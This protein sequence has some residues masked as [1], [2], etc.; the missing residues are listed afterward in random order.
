MSEAS[1]LVVG[2]VALN[3]GQLVSKIRLQKTVYLL[4]QCGLGGNFEF[5]YRNYGPFSI[6]VA[7]AADDAVAGS[8]LTESSRPGHHAEPYTIYETE[9]HP[10]EKL[11][12]VSSGDLRKK[13]KVMEHYSSLELEVA[14]TIV[15]LQ[16]QGHDEPSSIAGTK[17]LK[18]L[19]AT[20]ERIA[21][22][23]ELLSELEL[24]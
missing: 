14:S 23:H 12:M 2:M 11:G 1:D 6:D 19:K 10:P 15:F 4:E 13:L 16:R 5:E 7:R 3:G 9:E 21:R 17:E 18:P 22:A 24:R 20:N 8:R